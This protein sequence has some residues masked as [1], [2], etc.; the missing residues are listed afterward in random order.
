MFS[1]KQNLWDNFPEEYTVDSI[2]L[3]HNNFGTFVD[4]CDEIYLQMQIH[5]LLTLLM[6]SRGADSFYNELLFGVWI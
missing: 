6:N 2:R 4:K 1:W 3:D 5:E